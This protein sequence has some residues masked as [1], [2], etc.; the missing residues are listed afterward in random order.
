VERLRVYSHVVFARPEWP[1]R[2]MYL[3]TAFVAC[4]NRLVFHCIND[5]VCRLKQ[6][7]GFVRAGA[8]AL[9]VWSGEFTSDI[10]KFSLLSRPDML[11]SS[12]VCY[13]V[14]PPIERNELN[15]LS[16]ASD[17]EIEANA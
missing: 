12:K 15:L 5:A 11:F 7:G 1:T 4:R 17:S 14:A 9:G 10:P 3:L 8:F 6:K 16:S 2:L 13:N